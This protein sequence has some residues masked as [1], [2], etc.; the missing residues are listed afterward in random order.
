M[1]ISNVFNKSKSLIIS[2]RFFISIVFF[3]SA[4]TKIADFQNTVI[5]FKDIFALSILVVKPM[6]MLLVLAEIIISGLVVFNLFNMQNIYTCIIYLLL[7]FNLIGIYLIAMRVD[8]CGCFGTEYTVK[9]IST[10]IKNI[11]LIGIVFILR[12]KENKRDAD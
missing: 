7:F 11:I 6:L 9:P 8:N 5:F 2:L 4:V 1:G 12:K 10:I 3:V